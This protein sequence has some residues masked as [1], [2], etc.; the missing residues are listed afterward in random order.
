MEFVEWDEK[1]TEDG[2]LQ[3]SWT[4]QR[5]IVVD[6]KRGPGTRFRRTQHTGS[7][8]MVTLPAYFLTD[9]PTLSDIKPENK[10]HVLPSFFSC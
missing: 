4:R 8:P 2:S 9:P 6:D 1:G 5:A 7:G 3:L 10:N